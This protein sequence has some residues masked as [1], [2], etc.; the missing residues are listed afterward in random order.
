MQAGP[1]DLNEPSPRREPRQLGDLEW[2]CIP[3]INHASRTSATRGG[4]GQPLAMRDLTVLSDVEFEE[5]VADLFAAELRTNVERFARG[6]DGGV[7]LRW[8]TGG[9][10]VAIGQCK[11]YAHSTFSQLL[12]AAK[13]EIPHLRKHQPQQY[14]FVTSRDL[15]PGQK[16]ELVKALRPW[17]A[18]P[19]DVLGSRDI[20][21]LITRFPGVEQAH[22]KLWLST[23]I[24]L[25]WATH[26]ELATRSAAL[27]SRIE[28][29]IPR[30]VTNESF[31]RGTAIL[32]EQRVC[33][34]AGLP[35]IGKT[36]L[37]YALVADAMS[38]GYEPVEVSSDINEAWAAYM[39]DVAQ[40]FLYDDFLGQLTFSERLG[41][42]EDARLGDFINKVAATK[43]KLLIMTTREYI[44]QDARRVYSR[45]TAIDRARHL[46]L[47][48]DDYTRKDR[49]RI[50]YNHLWH[51]GLPATA[52]AEVA[53]DGCIDII[54]H[55]NY[56]PRLIEYCTGPGLDP[57]ESG[58]PARFLESLEHPERLWRTAFED[59]LTE[60]QQLVAVVLAS[61]P[62][63]VELDDLEEAHESLCRKRGVPVTAALYRTALQVLEG[64]FLASDMT[65]GTSQVRFHNPSVRAFVLDWL[66]QDRSLT[67][68]LIDSS[69]FFEQVSNI[70]QFATGHRAAGGASEP[71]SAALTRTVSWAR[72]SV[73]RALMRL[74]TSPTPERGGKYVADATTPLASWFEERLRFLVELPTDMQP[75]SAWIATQLAA[76]AARWTRGKGDKRRAAQLVELL[77][78]DPDQLLPSDT[79]EQAA[80]VLDSWLTRDLDETEEDW[81]PYLER[82]ERVHGVCL[83]DADH[84]AA[85]FEAHAL[86][87]LDRWSPSPPDLMELLEYAKRFQLEDLVITLEEKA[88]EDEQ[89]EEE[90]D[91][92]RAVHVSAAPSDRI[93][94]DEL[95]HMFARLGL[96]GGEQA[97]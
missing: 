61:L 22:P 56:S 75:S 81:M 84:V 72:A 3:Q 24:Q 1:L 17:V 91:Q 9:D 23:G 80:A 78:R 51:A 58:Y 62:P 21:G 89:R 29:V 86:N 52:L 95:R 85:E 83:K 71:T 53:A 35:G 31:A 6:P 7:D 15:T 44:L 19:D 49:A 74:I 66:A 41:K 67:A 69:T 30:Y 88:L 64:T 60:L 8:I 54:D 32:D 63:T 33:V 13:R 4:W 5:L 45:L 28:A 59:H 10:K 14:R 47:E 38:R 18:R 2:L 77:E 82:L 87:E 39:P 73:I 34:I 93:S 40:V 27:R 43:S 48:L 68:D 70:Y 50:L 16:D 94:D 76:A 92:R 25:F 12:A 42:N 97:P 65:F 37:A 11:H 55:P 20:D 79:V 46:I 90:P 57:H 96:V 36:T 26:S